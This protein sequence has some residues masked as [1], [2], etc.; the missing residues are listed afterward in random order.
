M[1]LHNGKTIEGFEYWSQKTAVGNSI[2]TVL[3]LIHLC[4]ILKVSYDHGVTVCEQWVEKTNTHFKKRWVFHNIIYTL[5]SEFCLLARICERMNDLLSGPLCNTEGSYS[6][7]DCI[8]P[9]FHRMPRL[10]RL[11]QTLLIPLLL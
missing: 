2:C 5:T 3:L 4:L 8:F 1:C 10:K 7:Q 9:P 6:Y 11:L